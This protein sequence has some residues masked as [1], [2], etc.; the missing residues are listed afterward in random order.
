MA[1]AEGKRG[2]QFLDNGQVNQATEIFESVLT[3]LG[4]TDV[5]QGRDSRTTWSLLLHKRPARPR[6]GARAESDRFPWQ[7][8]AQRR[9][10]KIAGAR[11][12]SELGDALRATGQHGDAKKAYEAAFKIAEQLN[13]LRS[14]GVDLARLG[15]LAL[16]EGNL[17]EALTRYLAARR[18]FQQPRARDGSGCLS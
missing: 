13:D 8:R 18:L 4:P 14:Q 1:R 15:A 5:R 11:W 10:E 12:R 3:R 17:E 9:S 2:Q 16:T 6:P 7:A